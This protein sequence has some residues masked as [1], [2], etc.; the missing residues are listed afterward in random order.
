LNLRYLQ[1]L[2]KSIPFGS[3]MVAEA[4]NPFLLGKRPLGLNV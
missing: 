1:Q 3:T 2:W 4:K